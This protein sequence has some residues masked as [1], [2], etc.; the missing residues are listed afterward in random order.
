MAETMGIL[1]KKIPAT[2]GHDI[3]II[4]H[5]S[6]NRLLQKLPSRM[7][8]YRHW[9]TDSFKVLVIVDRDDDDC[10]KLKSRLERM[11]WVSRHSGRDWRR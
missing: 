8:A 11:A 1:L 2:T 9:P 6:K 5:G 10:L 4:D 7:S 3:A